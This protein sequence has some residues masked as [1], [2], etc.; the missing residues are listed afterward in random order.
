MEKEKK[1]WQGSPSQINN[2]HIH[3]LNLVLLY[4]FNR[5]MY[6]INDLLKI[7]KFNITLWLT[8]ILIIISTYK[9]IETYCITYTLYDHKIGFKRGIFN[10]KYDETELYR[11][12]DYSIREPLFLRIFGLSNFKM[13]SSDK[14]FPTIEFK[15]ISKG[16]W[17]KD[18][19][20]KRVEKDRRNKGVREID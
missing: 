7:E 2:L 9:I 11:I 13:E 17:L 4:G 19:I 8:I 1:I 5:Y 15:A 18:E 3:L 20:R 10:V 12:K 14:Y 6:I 16:Y